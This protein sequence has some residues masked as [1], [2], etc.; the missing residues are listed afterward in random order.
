[1][2]FSDFK[3]Q[4]ERNW[5]ENKVLV[6]PEK[7]KMR[8]VEPRGFRNQ[9]FQGDCR[10]AFDALPDESLSLIITSPPYWRARYYESEPLYYGV[11]PSCDHA[12]TEHKYKL[13]NTHLREIYTKFQSKKAVELT[14]YRVCGKCNAYHGELGQEPSAD[15]FVEHLAECFAH[16]YKKL[17]RDGSCWVNMGYKFDGKLGQIDVPGKLTMAMQRRGWILREIIHWH[18]P[19]PMPSSTARKFT[20]DYEIFL[21]FVKDLKKYFF[22]TQYEPLKSNAART[23]GKNRKF[24]DEWGEGFYQ[25]H[26]WDPA[27]HHGKF[28]R[29]TWT[30][31]TGQ[32][33]GAHFAVYPEKL[34]EAPIDACCPEYICSTCGKARNIIVEKGKTFYAEHKDDPSH[35]FGKSGRNDGYFSGNSKWKNEYLKKK[36]ATGYTDCGCELKVPKEYQ[37]KYTGVSKKD[38]QGALAQNP[39]DS[40]RRMLK[41]INTKKV[42]SGYTGCDCKSRFQPGVVFDPFMGS[43]TTA[44][45]AKKQGKHYCGAE[46]NEEYNEIAEKRIKETPFFT[47]KSG[48]ELSS[49]ELQERAFGCKGFEHWE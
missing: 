17:R 30:I 36:T 21:W 4:L 46:M 2:E 35:K 3:E 28:K 16:G 11:D 38:Y 33:K 7:V 47:L 6:T 14:T 10:D 43:G 12:W 24:S 26:E 23:A 32:F 1:M 25:D 34:I 48:D 8:V 45:V 13:S 19:N 31:A 42:A 39:S 5:R 41:S 37:E 15:M 20:I 40:K 49:E 27:E 44:V 22:K 9:I 18:K 29:T